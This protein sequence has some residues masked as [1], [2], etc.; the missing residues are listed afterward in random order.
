MGFLIQE[1]MQKASRVVNVTL[2][3]RCM[4]RPSKGSVI[5]DCNIIINKNLPI[6]GDYGVL[7][8]YRVEASILKEE[9]SKVSVNDHILD[10]AGDTWRITMMTKET[11]SKW[12]VDVVQI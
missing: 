1:V 9:V 3:A 12:Y 4:Y 2:G 10:A 11:L 8:G 7:A 5:E 6:T